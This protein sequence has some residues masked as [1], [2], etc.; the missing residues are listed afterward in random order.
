[1]ALMAELLPGAD[2]GAA[3]GAKG[4]GVL[5]QPEAGAT[6]TAEEGAFLGRLPAIRAIGHVYPKIKKVAGIFNIS[7]YFVNFK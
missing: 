6:R 3:M 5:R 2:P 4:P 7:F 1:M